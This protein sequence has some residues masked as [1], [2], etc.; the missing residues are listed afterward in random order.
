M[1]QNERPINFTSAAFS[2][3]VKRN[4]GKLILFGILLIALIV[5]INESVFIVGEAD[6]S[7]VSRFG[8]IKQIVISR[9]NDFHERYADLLKDEI[10]LSQGVT[11]VVGS[12][13]H[14]KVPFVDKVETYS[15]RLYTYISDS[16]VVNTA[17]KKQYYVQ[18]YAQWYI[19]DPALFSLK[20]GSMRRSLADWCL[21]RWV[22]STLSRAMRRKRW[23]LTWKRSPTTMRIRLRWIIWVRLIIA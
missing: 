8:V 23:T 11:I 1:S 12:G 14:F 17:E 18:T 6:Q 9:K 20:L 4:R 19:A 7:V 22:T 10:S 21:K 15:A 13:L 2:A 16:E 5:L 3:S